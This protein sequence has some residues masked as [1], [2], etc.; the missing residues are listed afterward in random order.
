MNLRRRI[1]LLVAVGLVVALAPLGV[2]A[3]GMLRAATGRILQERLVMTQTLADHL[4]DR[5]RQE[6]GRLQ[7]LTHRTPPGVPGEAA[8]SVADDASGSLIREIVLV[9][10]L[11]RPVAEKVS[12]DVQA[13]LADTA[14]VVRASVAVGRPGVS[15]AV[16]LPTGAWA[17]VVVVPHAAGDGSGARAAVGVIPL[18]SP[19]L[20]AFVGGLVV[21][22]TGHAAIVDDSGIVL[23]SSDPAELFT[24][25]EH[26][27]FVWGLMGRRRSDVGLALG[28]DPAGR[29]ERHVM[30]FA[31]LATAPWG[32]LLGQEESE[33]YGPLWELRDR[34]ILF[35]MGVLAVALLFAWMDT[36][37]VAAPLRRL[38]DA[39]QA[40]A[41]GDLERQITVHRADEVGALA[42]AFEQMRRQVRALLQE[43][44]RRA[45]A[46]QSLY[47]A[48]R[49][50]LSQRGLDAILRSIVERA[51]ALVPGDVVVLCLADETSQV[52]RVGAI[53]GAGD[54]LRPGAHP[55][56]LRP[57]DGERWCP[58]CSVLAPAYRTSH[59]AVPLEVGGRTVGALCVGARGVRAFSPEEREVLAGLANLAAMAVENA[60]LQER[61]RSLAVAEERERIAREI[62]DSVGQVLGYVNT[63]VQAVRVLLEG[64]RTAEARAHLEQLERAARDVYADLREAIL[65]L[66]T[67][68]G[69][70]RP[71]V[72]VLG[73][74]AARFSDL[75]GVTTEVVV[76]GDP[77]WYTFSP[78][79]ELH[80]LRIVQE[81][82]TNVRRHARATRAWVR[83]STDGGVV[84]VSVRD[85]GVGFDRERLP[86]QRSQF[87]LQTMR[88]RAEAIGAIFEIRSREGEGT[89]VTVRV[90]LLGPV[91]ANARVAG[92]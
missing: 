86:G 51:A 9:D 58:G 31:P 81:A 8:A 2:M 19:T 74:Y 75:S 65:G 89:E 10:P 57:G 28:T 35:G 41:T 78:I 11:G 3:V 44:H 22:A 72:E 32:L 56:P 87:G 14:D 82:L 46:A 83:L 20:Q 16:R 26:A 34:T 49:D 37:A 60:R 47:E 1:M 25:G 21:G 67:E 52:A 84:T 53:W 71:L 88:E 48:G 64:G 80:L 38:R 15:R 24:R 12:G 85:N 92:G 45:S 36:G 68:T 43:V 30:A 63:K 6:V 50:V 23:A 4:D 27:E 62:H 90:P 79:A 66:R 77:A 39:A 7:R 18:P 91:V 13:L 69:P 5:L 17:A 55:F 42:S 73:D 40:I 54:A 29:S 33:T 70:A 61:I 59:L 76:E